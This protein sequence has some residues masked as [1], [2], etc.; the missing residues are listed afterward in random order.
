M[1]TFCRITIQPPLFEIKLKTFP[2]LYSRD[3]RGSESSKSEFFEQ[4][5][6][7]FY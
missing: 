2:V 7:S 6:I 3:P 1:E 4:L 5:Q